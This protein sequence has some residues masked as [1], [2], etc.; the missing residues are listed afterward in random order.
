M[1]LLCGVLGVCCIAVGFYAFVWLLCVPFIPYYFAVSRRQ[2]LGAQVVAVI[3][4]WTGI[5]MG[6]WLLSVK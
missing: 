4:C 5:W 1:T 6:L 2:E 3:V